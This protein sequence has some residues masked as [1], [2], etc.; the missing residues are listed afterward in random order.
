MIKVVA[1]V[2]R[3]PHLSRE[4]FQRYWLEHHGPLVASFAPATRVRRYVQVHTIEN[5]AFDVARAERGT[6][7]PYD[8]VAEL[9]WESVEQRSPTPERVKALTTIIE[10]ER[11]FIDLSRSPFMIGEEHILIDG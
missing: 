10:D 4:A 5:P 2:R 3:L 6:P 8:G 9:W 1:C 7:E 11:R